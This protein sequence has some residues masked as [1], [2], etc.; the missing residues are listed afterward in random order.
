MFNRGVRQGLEFD[1]MLA[2]FD[3]V[4]EG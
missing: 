3:L 4:D 1:R 2:E